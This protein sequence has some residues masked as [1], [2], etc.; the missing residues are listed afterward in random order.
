MSDPF[1]KVFEEVKKTTL[2]PQEKQSARARI[3][4]FMQEHPV[5]VRERSIWSMFF[6]R[7]HSYRVVPMLAVLVLFV[8]TFVTALA[9]ETA[10]PGDLLYPL[11]VH[12]AEEL[13]GTLAFSDKAKVEWDLVRATRRLEEAEKLAQQGRLDEKKKQRLREDYMVLENRVTDYIMAFKEKGAVS[14]AEF[15]SAKFEAARQA[16]Q[17]MLEQFIGPIQETLDVSSDEPISEPTPPETPSKPPAEL[18]AV[19]L[20]KKE[21]KVEKKSEAPALTGPLPSEPVLAKNNTEEALHKT[22]KALMKAQSEL[23]EHRVEM[24]LEDI[25]KV[26]DTMSEAATLLLEGDMNSDS[27]K[28]EEATT[29]FQE[30]LKKA[31]EAISLVR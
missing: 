12:V 14:D 9:S 20:Q 26:E 27:K 25:T 15:A 24:S 19:K 1:Q 29:K 18:P 2:L 28:F 16:H 23:H 17:E 5:Q 6:S 31:E 30:A 13:R 8:T 22:I 4:S 3:V 10:L 7:M 21:Q 11:K